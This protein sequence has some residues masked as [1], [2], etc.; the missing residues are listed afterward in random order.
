MRNIT[1]VGAGQAGLVLGLGLLANGYRVKL[2]TSETAA[3]IGAGPIRSAQGMFHE[4]LQ[5]ER[6][7]GLNTWDDAVPWMRALQFA[8]IG[9]DG[10]P[11]IAWRGELDAPAASVDQR[12]KFPA[13]MRA[14]EQQGGRIEARSAGVADL[15]ELARECELLVVA[16]G[17]ADVRKL[18]AR[19]GAKSPFDAPQRALAMCCVKNTRPYDPVRVSFNL[20]PGVGEIFCVP[21]WGA[22]GACEFVLI[23][24]SP[25]GRST[26]STAPP[27]RRT[28]SRS[29]SSCSRRSCPRSSR[30]S[31]TPR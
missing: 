23:E 15:E 26:G 17:K 29:C 2:V 3:Q 19:D 1:I 24:R 20:V 25:A 21:S 10:E 16:A 22:H 6:D 12:L 11:A 9:P 4:A 5:I 31:R 28:G 7:L 30:A 14:F 8:L 18:F 13:W 27:R